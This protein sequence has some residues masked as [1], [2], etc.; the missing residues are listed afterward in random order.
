MANV[1]DF[2]REELQGART[3]S[4]QFEDDPGSK[5]YLEASNRVEEFEEAIVV[6]AIAT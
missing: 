2:L 4:K 3:K 6:H 1:I 5:E